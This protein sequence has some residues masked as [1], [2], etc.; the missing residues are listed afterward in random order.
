MSGNVL[1]HCGSCFLWTLR[2]AY[3]TS[4]HAWNAKSWLALDDGKTYHQLPTVSATE[5]R[6]C[7]CVALVY[8]SIAL[9]HKDSIQP[10]FPQ[11]LDLKVFNSE[12]KEFSKSAN[13]TRHWLGK[14]PSI[15]W[16]I[17]I[18][19]VYSAY[20]K[21]KHRDVKLCRNITNNAQGTLI[22]MLLKKNTKAI[23]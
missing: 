9:S 17:R 16:R 23:A 10:S 3:I 4:T 13:F 8:G 19:F 21:E 15:F 7:E 22:K 12:T 18:L 14:T 2:H 11:R 20:L 5:I 6:I 1:S